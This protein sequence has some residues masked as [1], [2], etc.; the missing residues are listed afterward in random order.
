MKSHELERNTDQ[1]GIIWLAV[2]AVVKDCIFHFCRLC[3]QD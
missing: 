3:Y 1:G 2:E